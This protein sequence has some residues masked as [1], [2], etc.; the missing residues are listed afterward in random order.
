MAN[1]ITKN[2]FKKYHQQIAKICKKKQNLLPKQAPSIIQKITKHITK[3]N[4]KYYQ[5]VIQTITKK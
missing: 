2:I 4:N 5:K 3:N 1:H